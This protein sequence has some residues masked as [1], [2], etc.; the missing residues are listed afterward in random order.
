MYSCMCKNHADLKKKKED[1]DDFQF[2]IFNFVI[3]YY[4]QNIIVDRSFSVAI[5]VLK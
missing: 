2:A 3:F 1:D 5:V 4:E